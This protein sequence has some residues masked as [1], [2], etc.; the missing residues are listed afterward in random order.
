MLEICARA[1]WPKPAP[2]FALVRHPVVW[3]ALGC[4]CLAAELAPAA[5]PGL[6][7]AAAWIEQLDDARFEVR[8]RAAAR[9][10]ELADRDECQQELAAALQERLLD[11][12]IS[13][14]VRSQLETLLKK[15]PATALPVP[16]A[17]VTPEQ[18]GQLIRQLDANK[19]SQ[20]LGAAARLHWLITRPELACRIMTRL[21]GTQADQ[22]L[23]AEAREQRQPVFEAARQA[24]LTS[25]PKQWQLPEVSEAEISRWLDQLTPDAL[26]ED[27]S[28]EARQART[29]SQ[30]AAQQELLDL[31]ARDDYVE[32]V[33][34]A[35]QR[36]LA[37]L[38]AESTDR[39]RLESLIEMTRPAMV[40]EYWEE[41][42]HL[43]IQHLLVDVPS[44]S[45]G[46]QRPSHFD[47]INDYVAHCVSG[48]SLSPGDYPVGVLF[49]HPAAT[50]A[51]SQF[52]L[53]NLPTPRRR[54]AYEYQV[55]REETVRLR[56]LSERTL[57]A[58][59]AQKR[60]LS[61]AELCM[62]QNL[63][64]GALS[65]FAGAYFMAGGDPVPPDREAQHRMGRASPCTNLCQVLA[66]IG[67][68]DA[69]AGLLAAIKAERFPEPTAES[70]EN[71]PW[72][73]VLSIA[74]RDP[75]PKDQAWLASLIERT[76]PL[77]LEGENPPELGATA[78][79]ILLMQ[80]D[81]PLT[82]FGLES[83]EDRMLAESGAPDYR[84]TSPDMREKVL[85]WW[86]NQ[87]PP[88]A[89]SARSAP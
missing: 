26:S 72:I 16:P 24:W 49:P 23:S 60:P 54:M 32:R 8:R 6:S 1:G 3:V 21:K 46:A 12:E 18:I 89:Q 73:A 29:A 4:A 45:E 61:E 19:Y 35:L 17:D 80:H 22:S 50:R 74:E 83:A 27:A 66:E 43:G 81:M 65:R 87:K 34:A 55:K 56:E 14:E 15:L 51:N 11:S 7:Q 53:V 79:A 67:T 10:E 62:V 76:D 71:W 2:L 39:F 63:D 84:F 47:R 78:A 44:R 28:S 33:K 30:D 77:R 38:D 58:I 88:V 20:R 42:H 25:D 64:D 13:F 75:R 70:P 40:A 85:R 37:E 82:K 59:A 31:L 36:R 86:A 9:L 68:H 52:H 48:N 41:K 57:A 69:I 5:E